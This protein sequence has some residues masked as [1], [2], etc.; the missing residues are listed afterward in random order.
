M[1]FDLIL[2]FYHNFNLKGNYRSGELPDYHAL[3]FVQRLLNA[4]PSH[5]AGEADEIVGQTGGEVAALS[6]DLDCFVRVIVRHF[7]LEL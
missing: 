6:T 4:L 5:F 7:D 3:P 1:H 2:L